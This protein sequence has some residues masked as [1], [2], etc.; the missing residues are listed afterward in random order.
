MTYAYPNCGRASEHAGS[1]WPR[2]LS[3]DGR[4]CR[5]TMGE[6][7]EE[8]PLLRMGGIAEQFYKLDPATIA[9][10]TGLFVCNPWLGVC[11]AV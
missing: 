3:D 9:D 11:C 2:L 8:K 4:Q 10:G 1:Q 5:V 6:N 7:R